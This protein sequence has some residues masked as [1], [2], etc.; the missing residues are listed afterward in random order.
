MSEESV[1]P[2]NEEEPESE[3]TCGRPLGA[4]HNPGCPALKP[5]LWTPPEKLDGN[6][7]RMAWLMFI[8]EWKATPLSTQIM[9]KEGAEQSAVDVSEWAAKIYPLCLAAAKT[10]RQCEVEAGGQ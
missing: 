2:K 9:D 4:E 6:V 1:E 7:Q 10:V 3:C 8:E 5:T